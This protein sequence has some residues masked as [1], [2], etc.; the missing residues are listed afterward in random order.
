VP[1]P[2]EAQFDALVNQAFTLHAGADT[3]LIEQVGRPFF[4]DSCPDAAEH[5]LGA[6][7]LEND[8]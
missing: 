5:V 3:C 4:D 6:A 8:V 7:L 2:T 1:L